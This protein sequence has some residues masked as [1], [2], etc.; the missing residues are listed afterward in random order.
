LFFVVFGLVFVTLALSSASRHVLGQWLLVALLGCGGL[1]VGVL[2]GPFPSTAL[3][4]DRE[5]C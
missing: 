2:E 3:G 5:K 1:V 4:Y